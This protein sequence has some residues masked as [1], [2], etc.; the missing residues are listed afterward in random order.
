[1]AKTPILVKFAV[2]LKNCGDGSAAA[3]PY[4][5]R[6]LAEQAA[7]KDDERFCE[8]VEEIELVVDPSTGQIISGVGTSVEED[9]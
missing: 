9:E 1:M 5:T 2:Y 7:E 3:V 6:E 4:A 8:D